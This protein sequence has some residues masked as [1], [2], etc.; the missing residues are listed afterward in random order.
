MKVKVA[1]RLVAALGFVG[2]ETPTPNDSAG[3]SDNVRLWSKVDTMLL[4]RVGCWLTAANAWFRR[5][6]CAVA[7]N[8]KWKRAF[9]PG[10]MPEPLHPMSKHLSLGILRVARRMHGELSLPSPSASL[11]TFKGFRAVCARL[12]VAQAEIARPCRPVDRGYLGATP[13]WFNLSGFSSDNR[14][15]SIPIAPPLPTPEH[16]RISKAKG[17]VFLPSAKDSRSHCARTF[18]IPNR[19]RIER[20]VRWYLHPSSRSDL[21][22]G[23]APR[24]KR[25]CNALHVHDNGG[26]SGRSG[27]HQRDWSVR[28][29]CEPKG[30]RRG[31]QRE[32]VRRR[33]REQCHP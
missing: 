6:L 5:S 16:E 14:A 2:K 20:P 12:H 7:C 18:P 25:L 33:F 3:C 10:T 26:Q 21:S 15:K 30:N 13:P 1:G 27:L 11:S 4:W 9:S 32:Y 8:R 29:V 24:T 31:Q 22:G 17:Q 23:G 19:D 28:L